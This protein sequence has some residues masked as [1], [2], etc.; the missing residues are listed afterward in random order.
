MLKISQ[1]PFGAFIVTGLSFASKCFIFSA[2]GWVRALGTLIKRRLILLFSRFKSHTASRKTL[3]LIKY[4]Y[5]AAGI[6][7][8]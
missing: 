2:P 5:I 8:I 6:I 3:V 1:A 4:I 7:K